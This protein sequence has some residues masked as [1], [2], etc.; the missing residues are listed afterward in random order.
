VATSFETSDD[1]AFSKPAEVACRHL[2]RDHRCAIHAQ[3]L[4]RGLSGCAVYDCYGAGQ[5]ATRNFAGGRERN[6]AFLILRVVHELLWFVTEAAKLCPASQHPLA[7]ELAGELHRLDAIAGLAMPL[8]R[9]VDLR[10]H[11]EVVSALLRRLGDALGGRRGGTSALVV[12][13]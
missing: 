5:R 3:L 13:D 9:E 2:R 8:L 6:E 10:V 11:R 12:L 7:I 4:E 1:F